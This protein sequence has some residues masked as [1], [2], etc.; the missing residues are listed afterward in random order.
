M[1]SKPKRKP[2]SIGTQ[3]PDGE[4]QLDGCRLILPLTP[5]K[6][7]EP[8][9][10]WSRR[11]FK[12]YWE[13]MAYCA[14]FKARKPQYDRVS[15]ELHYYVVRERDMDNNNSL[16]LKGIIDGLVGSMIPD[17]NPRVLTLLPATQHKVKRAEQRLE[18][19][20]RRQTS[21]LPHG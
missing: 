21:Q 4:W 15:I 5:S 1:L 8:A 2:W 14:W 20:V 17:D 6:N 7:A 13:K 9:N 12:E 11:D 16:A 3:E 18:M 19:I 10:K